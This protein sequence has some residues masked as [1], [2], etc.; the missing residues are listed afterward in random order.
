MASLPE[1]CVSCQNFEKNYLDLKEEFL[2]MKSE[3]QTLRQEKA[4][5]RELIEELL[6]G[7]DRKT[8]GWTLVSKGATKFTLK[9]QADISTRNSFD[10]LR[11]EC[12]GGGNVSEVESVSDR[13]ECSSRQCQQKK[14]KKRNVCI[15]GDSQVRY[16]DRA[17]HTRLAN[18]ACLPG[19]KVVNVCNKLD[20]IIKDSGANP[21]VCLSVGGNDIGKRRSEALWQQYREMLDR[22]RERGGTPVV[23]GILPRWRVGREWLSRAIGFNDRLE[24]YCKDNAIP[25]IDNWSR[26]YGRNALYAWDGTH[27]SRQGVSVLART[28]DRELDE[29]FRS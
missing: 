26:F 25:F 12:Q 2:K 11:D 5:L 24:R 9:K 1:N 14:G 16:L 27:L 19:A 28:I 4:E 15:V 6:E 22:V 29:F 18:H 21:T 17:V 23:L 8:N 10:T 7:K 13:S 20:D 3:M